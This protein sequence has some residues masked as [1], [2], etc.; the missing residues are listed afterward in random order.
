MYISLMN[1]AAA[2][3][4]VALA[5]RTSAQ[6]G[7]RTPV[8]AR[9]PTP[10][11]LTKTYIRL[12][13]GR[14]V[15]GDVLYA[16]GGSFGPR[17]QADYQLV[18]IHSGSLTLTIDDEILEVPEN[19]A[20]LLIPGH[21]EF[22]CFA[23]DCETRHSW[24]A[25]EPGMLAEPLRQELERHRGP[26]PFLGRMVTLLDA[27]RR[28]MVHLPEAELLQNS[29][30]EALATAILCAFASTVFDG[31]RSVQASTG[32]LL[33]MEHFIAEVYSRPTTL[34]DIAR[35]AGASRQ[36][37]LK[38][39]RVSGRNTPTEQLYAKRLE[40]AA[41]LLLH[42]G[43]TIAQIAEQCGFSNQFHFSRKFK[44][45]SGRSPSAWRGEVW[46]QPRKHRPVAISTRSHVSRP[47]GVRDDGHE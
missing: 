34:N 25:V 45:A 35:A 8:P 10:S 38:L 22:F 19:F 16:Q 9:S 29:A 14:V 23:S 6:H 5:A 44:Q 47:E 2:Q 28:S 11:L 3:M 15:V 30:H 41:D 36:H 26:A 40:A 21:T 7:L 39:C 13:R 42:T 27:A 24:I 33:R 17:L 31:S 20:V 12:E 43:L 32:V 46:T 4:Q 37:L 18:V 1:H